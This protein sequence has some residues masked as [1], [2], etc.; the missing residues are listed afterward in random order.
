MSLRQPGGSFRS[1]ARPE[2]FSPAQVQ[3]RGGLLGKVMGLLAF[4]F[5]FAI[6]G[7]IVGAGLPPVLILPLFLVEIGLIFGVQ[8]ARNRQGLNLI[9]LYAFAF[10]S[11]MTFGL[12]IAYYVGAGL[13]SIVLQ[14]AAITGVMTVGLS[15]YALTTKRDF[16]G[17]GVYLFIG[18]LGLIVASIV[19]I[20]FG[21]TL[22]QAVLGFGGAILFSFYLIY[23][24]QKT[25][26]WENTMGNAVV[27]ALGVYLDIVNLFFSILRLL[28]ATSG[29]G[30]R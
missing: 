29:G 5:V 7:G 25:R 10:V 26:T 28:G 20:F 3:A 19:G 17:I 12:P 8:W 27:I 24:V 18:L 11:G 14:A 22:L 2:P 1:D 4:T 6:V 30:R 23:D 9:L 21:G 15:L 16:S 13:G